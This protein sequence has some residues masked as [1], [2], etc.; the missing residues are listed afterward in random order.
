MKQNQLVEKHL[1]SFQPNELIIASKLFN[2]VIDEDVSN[3]GEEKMR[4][5]YHLTFW[6]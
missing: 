6:F 4:F 2:D 5:G 1:Q 3:L